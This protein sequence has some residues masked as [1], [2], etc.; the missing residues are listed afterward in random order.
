[1]SSPKVRTGLLAK[2]WLKIVP[3]PAI[4]ATV[5]FAWISNIE[6]ELIVTI[7]VVGKVFTAPIT[8]LPVPP[9]VVE[10]V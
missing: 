7:V 1:M 10:L 3:V 9:T 8:N 6:P 5:W 4:R 2:P